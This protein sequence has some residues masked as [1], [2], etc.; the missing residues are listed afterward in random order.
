MHMGGDDYPYIRLMVAQGMLLWQLV[1][2]GGCLQMSP[3]T[4]FTF[5]A[6]TFDN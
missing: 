2:F 4:T 6:L 3:Q 1:K 5:F